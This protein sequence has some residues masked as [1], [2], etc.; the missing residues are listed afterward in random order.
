MSTD[1]NNYLVT[2]CPPEESKWA[3][4][5][6]YLSARYK[7]ELGFLP[8][9][10]YA[11]AVELG[12]VLLCFENGDPCGY[13][14]HGPARRETKIYQVVIADDCRRIEHGTALV[15]A[16]RLYA[17]AA[18]AHALSC[19]VA[20]DLEAVHFWSAIGLSQNGSRCR[21]K[22][23]QRR[24]IRFEEERPGKSLDLLDLVAQLK[25]SKLTQLHAF[26]LKN[27]PSLHAVQ[28][29]RKATKQHQIILN[30]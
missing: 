9:T 7:H 23:K 13:A 18:R 22:D 12:R 8:R 24:Q 4:F 29:K 15:E 16:V 5:L 25:E 28:F 2:R 10:A 3:K 6:E 30:P 14:I 17:D 1:S 27:N 26:L 19:H 11:Q 20:E 21:R